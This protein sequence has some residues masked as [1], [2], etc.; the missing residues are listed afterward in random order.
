M[1]RIG[2]ADHESFASIVGR[3]RQVEAILCGHLHRNIQTMVGG[4]RVLTCPSP[5][6]QVALDLRPDAPSCYRM[7][8][9]GFM[10]HRWQHDH[11]VSHSV[12]IGD[13]DGPFPFFTPEGRL[14]R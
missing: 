11:L 2:L 10:L 13:F 6:H 1:D 8:P 12:A 14:I 7:E 4:R 5:A 3:H 9:P